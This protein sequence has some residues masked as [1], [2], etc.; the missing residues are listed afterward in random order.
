MSSLCRSSVHDWT[1][2]RLTQER[3]PDRM[4]I[5]VSTYGLLLRRTSVHIYFNGDFTGRG[6]SV[7][8][9][10]QH[11]L[12]LSTGP[13]GSEGISTYTSLSK[14]RKTLVSSTLEDIIH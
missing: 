13:Q 8:V 2:D 11:D 14:G 4:H 3:I 5:T 9:R 7:F 1:L 10:S 12:S 6:M